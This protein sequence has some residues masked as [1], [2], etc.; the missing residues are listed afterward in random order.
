M[1]ATNGFTLIGTLAGSPTIKTTKGGSAMV[2]AVLSVPVTKFANGG[3]FVENVDYEFTCFGRTAEA[4]KAL[5]EGQ[6]IAV[7]GD[8]DSRVFQRGAGGTGLAVSLTGREITVIPTAVP[9]GDEAAPF[10]DDWK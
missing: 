4:A 2:I 9:A 5:S 8:I 7:S 1:S 10:D 3:N 6:L